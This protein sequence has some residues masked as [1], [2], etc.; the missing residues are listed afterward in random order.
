MRRIVRAE[1]GLTI[2]GPGMSALSD[3]YNYGNDGR[4]KPIGDKDIPWFEDWR[5][6]VLQRADPRT[7]KQRNPPGV[8]IG[9]RV[10]FNE[11]NL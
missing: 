2:V 3:V 6:L 7:R 8:T 10:S 11:K 1:E 4:K 9:M 5:E